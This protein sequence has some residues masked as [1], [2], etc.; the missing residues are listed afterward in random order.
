[1]LNLPFTPRFRSYL[2]SQGWWT[3]EQEQETRA[4]ER[5]VVLQA[6]EKVRVLSTTRCEN[7]HVITRINNPHALRRRRKNSSHQ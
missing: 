3:D 7:P 5:L 1:M 6:L 4:D 2:E